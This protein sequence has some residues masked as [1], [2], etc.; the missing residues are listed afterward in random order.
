MSK[1]TPSE[2][3]TRKKPSPWRALRILGKALLV[4]YL[5]HKL[6][7]TNSYLEGKTNPSY[8]RFWLD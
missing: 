2:L 3:E 6:R 1:C 4:R 5:I 7:L 8:L